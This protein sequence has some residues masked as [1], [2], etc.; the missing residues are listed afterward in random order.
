MCLE[1]IERE[2]RRIETLETMAHL[3]ERFG[4]Y[5][6]AA[7]RY[8]RSLQIRPDHLPTWLLLARAYHRQGRSAEAIAVCDRALQCEPQHAAFILQKAQVQDQITQYA[9]AWQTLQPLLFEGNTSAEAAS[10]ATND[11]AARLR[12]FVRKP[13]R[14]RGACPSRIELRRWRR[15]GP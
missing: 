4:D 13:S 7:E 5:S 6:S 11:N 12:A 2:P 15:L 14:R 10:V 3:D 8:E 1:V 9:A